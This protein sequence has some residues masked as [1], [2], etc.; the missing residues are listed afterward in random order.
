MAVKVDFKKTLKQ[1]YNPSIK[2]FHILEVPAMNFLMVDGKGDPNTSIV[3]QQAIEALYG[4]SYGIKFALKP[5]GYDYVIPPMEGLWWMDDM[6]EFNRA[7][8]ARWE[9]TM[10]IMQLEWVTAELVDRV[11]ADVIKKKGN[12]NAQRVRYDYYREGLAVQILYIGAY[13]DEAPVIAEMHTF[14]KNSGYEIY[15]KHHEVY[16]SD[17]RKTSPEKLQTILRQPIRKG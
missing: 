11:R 7:N 2:G 13:A 10:M 15:G 5:Q 8:I 12:S 17:V 4:V 9:W 6:N 3:Y 1:L 14:V 16:L